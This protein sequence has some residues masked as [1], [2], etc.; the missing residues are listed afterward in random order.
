MNQE[1]R[2]FQEKLWRGHSAHTGAAL[3]IFLIIL[4]LGM[5]SLL[6]SQLNDRTTLI[7]E[8]QAH[9]TKALIQAKE[10]LLGYAANY[11]DALDS[12]GVPFREYGFL[13]CTDEEVRDTANNNEEGQEDGNCAGQ[14]E[15]SLGRL[16]WKTL[17]IPPLR[18][19]TGE[20]LWYAISGPYKNGSSA[21][22]EMLNEDT[23]GLFEV[24]T[25]PN[26]VLGS[27]PPKDRVVAVVIAPGRILA[28]QQ[29]NAETGTE[30]CGGNYTPSNY[31]DNYSSLPSKEVAR[32]I[33]TQGGDSNSLV[34]DRIISITR[35]E[36]WQ[37]IRKRTDFL[38]NMRC[39]TEIASVCVGNYGRD[40]TG[41]HYL[42]WPAP[43]DLDDYNKELSYSDYRNY[44]DNASTSAVL[45]RLPNEV[46]DSNSTSSVTKNNIITECNFTKVSSSQLTR[47]PDLQLIISCNPDEYAECQTKLA[48]NP[49]DSCKDTQISG[50]EGN[51]S[52]RNFLKLWKNWKDHLFYAAAK[53][54]L[55][56]NVDISYASCQR[57]PGTPLEHCCSSSETPSETAGTTCTS[58]NISCDKC[59]KEET[60]IGTNTE[61]NFYPAVVLFAGEPLPSQFRNAP[62]PPGEIDTKN[63]VWNYLDNNQWGNNTFTI[64]KKDTTLLEPTNLNED[65]NDIMSWVSW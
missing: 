26:Y 35:E 29:R 18:D 31:L 5:S 6:L 47:C 4:I 10:A 3:L 2:V 21:K 45:G 62:P 24:S 53:M 11:Y 13:P 39:L 25:D 16:P 64:V 37:F 58:K 41:V 55:P 40:V 20:C 34:N 61:T 38:N 12:N 60:Q 65:I 51:N 7:L 17:G 48:I 43:I 49:E 1:Q 27:I 52:V 33:S 15:S 22:T 63:R 14:D 44:Q 28:G 19:G 30:L 42:P 46:G 8:E 32:F 9:T 56:D 36:L 54:H 23:N 50:C 57:D 59:I